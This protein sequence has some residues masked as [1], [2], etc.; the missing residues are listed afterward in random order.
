MKYSNVALLD[1]VLKIT[2]YTDSSTVNLN[3]LYS[4]LIFTTFEILNIKITYFM[5]TNNNNKNFYA[6]DID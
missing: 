4:C 1:Q 2:L 3:S 6:S 5:K